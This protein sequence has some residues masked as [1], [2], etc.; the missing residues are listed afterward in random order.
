MTHR[1]TV[2]TGSNDTPT[3]DAFSFSTTLGDNLIVDAN[4]FL[5][6]Q[7]AGVVARLTGSWTVAA[8][9]TGTARQISAS[10]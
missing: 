4:A 1:I 7:S 8:T 3:G 9:S 2:K 6:S 10:R 5:I